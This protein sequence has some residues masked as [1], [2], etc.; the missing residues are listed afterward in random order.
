V[1]ELE[2]ALETLQSQV[3]PE[4]HPLLEES[5]RMVSEMLRPA[6]PGIKTE[7]VEDETLIDTFGSLTIDHK[8]QTTW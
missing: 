2:I 3:T 8:G 5:L 7:A 1:K 6:E 4:P